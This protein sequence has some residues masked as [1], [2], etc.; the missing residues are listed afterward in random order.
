[1][2][3]REKFTYRTTLSPGLMDMEK[4]M[5]LGACQCGEIR[6]EV[7]C[8]KLVG[9]ACHCLECQKQTSS[10]FALSIPIKSSTISI[11]GERAEYDRPAKSGAMTKCFYCPSCGTRIYHQSSRSPELL[12]LKGGTL[13]NGR[14]LEPIAHLW[15]RQMHKWVTLPNDIERYEEQPNDISSWRD[16]LLA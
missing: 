6:Y 9:Y 13:D 5:F 11:H 7:K 12:T 2:R 10:A 8:D 1:M 3:R 14:D 4:S 15:T 16:K